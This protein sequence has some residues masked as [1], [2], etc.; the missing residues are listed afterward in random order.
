MKITGLAASTSSTSI[1]K[2][3][4]NYVLT[5]YF[6]DAV[7]TLLDL[8]DYEMP[9]F[10]VDRELESGHPE[11]AHRFLED[12]GRADLLVISMAEHNGNYTAAFKNTFDWASRVN[13]K[14][15][16]NKPVLLLSTSPGGYGA[17][18]SLNAA[19]AR[20]PKHGATILATFSLPSFEQNFSP[21]NGITDDALRTE[22]ETAIQL[23]KST[24]N[25]Q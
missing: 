15:F 23:V 8:N 2:Q 13:A 4:V 6:H 5:H 18:N 22:L 10:S 14:V 11:A 16:Q 1:N 19:I 9:L 25:E 24:L 12:L 21:E 3:L 7:Q 20:F 17:K